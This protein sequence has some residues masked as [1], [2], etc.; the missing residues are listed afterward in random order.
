MVN[1]TARRVIA[2]ELCQGG[3]EVLEVI[4]HASML[5]SKVTHIARPAAAWHEKVFH[6]RSKK[7][8]PGQPAGKILGK[9]ARQREQAR[10][11]PLRVC[12][13]E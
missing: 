10:R 12:R 7:V 8:Q 6:P 13:E 11:R 3:Y 1:P 4:S 5:V 9:K 2:A